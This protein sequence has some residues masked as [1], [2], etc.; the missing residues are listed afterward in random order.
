MTFILVLLVLAHWRLTRVVTDDFIL[1][2][3]RDW[4]DQH[5]AYLGYLV[6]CTY[7]FGFWLAAPFAW[8]GYQ[9]CGLSATEAWLAWPALSATAV[10]IQKFDEWEPGRG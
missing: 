10:F 6:A 9:F 3:F 1:Q 5:A 2:W 4:L 7:C 8:V